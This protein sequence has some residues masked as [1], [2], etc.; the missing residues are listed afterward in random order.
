[1]GTPMSVPRSCAGAV[2]WTERRTTS[3]PF[4][5]SPWMPPVRHTTGPGRVPA[6]TITGVETSPPTDSPTGSA[7]RRVSPGA[8]SWPRTTRGSARAP[9][10]SATSNAVSRPPNVMRGGFQLKFA[11]AARVAASAGRAGGLLAEEGHHRAG[12]VALGACDTRVLQAHRAGSHG[13]DRLGGVVRVQRL[14]SLA[15]FLRARDQRGHPLDDLA[16]YLGPARLQLLPARDRLD[17]T[18]RPERSL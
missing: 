12:Q 1:M 4:S 13:H 6:T 14:A 10:A 2:A 3:A 5:S 8:I 7:R 18:A 16:K 11:G 17:Q 15:P 9:L